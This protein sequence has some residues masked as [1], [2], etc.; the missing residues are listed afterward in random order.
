MTTCSR[1]QCSTH[2]ILLNKIKL[3]HKVGLCIVHASNP[4]GSYMR[5]GDR[6][7]EVQNCPCTNN[8]S[9]WDSWY[10]F[11]LAYFGAQKTF[12]GTFLRDILVGKRLFFQN[13]LLPDMHLLDDIQQ[14]FKA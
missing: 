2:L 8:S 9:L 11:E 1:V 3:Q 14:V 12:F 7:I 10:V 13:N 6:D 4:M 5:E